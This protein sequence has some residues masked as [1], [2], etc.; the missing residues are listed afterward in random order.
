MIDSLKDISIPTRVHVTCVYMQDRAFLRL[1]C[2]CLIMHTYINEW[3]QCV[4]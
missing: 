4:Q 3:R 2:V 1:E